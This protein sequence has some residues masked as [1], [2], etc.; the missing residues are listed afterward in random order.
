MTLKN[1]RRRFEEYGYEV[2][3]DSWPYKYK[4]RRIGTLKW[5]R[6][7]C[8]EALLTA[9]LETSHERQFHKETDG[10]RATAS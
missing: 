8:L 2:E 7:N 1:A 10:R 6:G 4:C 3:R 9:T 5:L